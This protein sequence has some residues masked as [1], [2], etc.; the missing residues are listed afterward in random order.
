MRHQPPRTTRSRRFAAG[1]ALMVQ[2]V[3]LAVPARP[4]LGQESALTSAED[5]TRRAA[6]MKQ[7]VE[8]FS[9]NRG[10]GAMARPAELRG[11]PLHRWNDPT[12]VFS[13][14]SLWAWGKAGRPVAVVALELYPNVEIVGQTDEAWS[15][16]FVSLSTEPFGVDGGQDFDR[17]YSDMPRPAPDGHIHWSP[18]KPGVVFHAMP[19]APAPAATPNVRL[20]QMK[21]FVKRFSAHEYYGAGDQRI[22]L[23][24]MP[25]PIERYADP[26]RGIVDGAIFLFANGTNPEVMILVEAWGRPPGEAAWHYAV[27][28]LS[29]A[30]SEVDLDQKQVWSVPFATM[31]L[32]SDPYFLARKPRKKP[33]S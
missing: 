16:E 3:V 24:P 26:D 22:E 33:S 7:I 4:L 10:E 13:D 31:Q 32:P 8:S 18:T 17:H 21:D 25:R 6:E 2:T 20:V 19:A 27:A 12:R 23:R 28:R 9:A 1:M 29:R 14:A 11:E 30:R 15:F 5:R